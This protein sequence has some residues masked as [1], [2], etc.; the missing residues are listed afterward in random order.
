MRKWFLQHDGLTATAMVLVVMLVFLFT[1]FQ[2]KP[3]VTTQ[4]PNRVQEVLP[5]VVHIKCDHWQG[6]GVALTE[7]IVVTARH[8]ID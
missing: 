8:V 4:F 6:S 1:P 7:D 3:A 2:I 5:S